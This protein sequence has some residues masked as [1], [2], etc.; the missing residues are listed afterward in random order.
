MK[1]PNGNITA[2]C[3]VGQSWSP[4]PIKDVLRDINSGMKSYYVQEQPRRSYVRAVS[5]ALQTTADAT[6]K[7]HLAGLPICPPPAP[8]PPRSRRAKPA[9]APRKSR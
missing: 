3:N 1:D 4:R 6:D 5:G 9:A 2:L 7:N 8:T